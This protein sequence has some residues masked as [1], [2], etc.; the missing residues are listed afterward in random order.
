MRLSIRLSEGHSEPVPQPSQ[1]ST[2]VND[3]LLSLSEMYDSTLSKCRGF[4]LQCSLY[5]AY[6]MGATTTERSKDATVIS[7]LTGW[8]LEWATA[9]WERGKEELGSHERFMALFRA[10]FD[11]PPECREGGE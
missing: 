11:H 5:F 4:L 1:L 8:A 9:V 10:I 2:Q 6:Q 3:A 7:L